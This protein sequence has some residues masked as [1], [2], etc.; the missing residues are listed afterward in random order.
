MSDG[1]ANGALTGERRLSPETDT[2]VT[3]VWSRRR[4]SPRSASRSAS[5]P[6]AGEA[7]AEPTP[8]PRAAVAARTGAAE[9]AAGRPLPHQAAMGIEQGQCRCGR[10]AGL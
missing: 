2:P 3:E 10:R 7:A 9:P 1:E 8:A 6:A 5:P 4:I